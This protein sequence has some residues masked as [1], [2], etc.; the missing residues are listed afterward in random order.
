MLLEIS[1]PGQ[2]AG[3]GATGD[4]ESHHDRDI[5]SQK[6]FLV[7]IPL[8]AFLMANARAPFEV[9]TSVVHHMQ[10]KAGWEEGEQ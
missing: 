5:F 10:W 6:G 9:I 3:H 2:C 7:D 1:L 8:I 4:P